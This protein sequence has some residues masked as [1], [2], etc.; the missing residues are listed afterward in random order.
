GEEMARFQF[1]EETARRIFT[2]HGYEELRTPVFEPTDL[3]VRGIGE[4]TD[5]VSKEMYTFKDRSERSLTLR[6][7]GT[8]G[9]VRAT[10][11]HGL[12]R[13]SSEMKV[14]YMGPMFRYERPQKGRQR[15]FHQIGCEWFG[16][17]SPWADAE[18][19][20]MLTIYLEA[21][22]FSGV[23]TRVNSIGARGDREAINSALRS[24]LEAHRGD[25][26]EDCQRRTATHPM[27]ALDCK[28]PGC[29]PTLDAAPPIVDLLSEASQTLF[30]EVC[31]HLETLGIEFEIAPRLVRGFDY[32]THT[33]F[34]TVL[35]GLGAQDAVLGGGR[36]DNL[37]EDLG[38]TSTPALGA[39]LGVE[40]LSLALQSLE[41]GPD[42]RSRV[43][44]AICLLDEAGLEVAARLAATCRAEGLRVRFDYQRR[45]P[46]AAL[47]DAN[48]VNAHFAALLGASEIEAQHVQLKDLESGNQGPVSFADLP[49]RLQTHTADSPQ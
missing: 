31:E 33:V 34:E 49:G 28:N 10:L 29:Q 46:K 17:A 40:R 6:P 16:N 23:R 9:V 35:P 14:F 42:L 41:A 38:G 21:C 7:E 2:I 18:T 22:G 24:H 26:C 37:F 12:L 20:A 5:I 43:D 19:I 45:S 32:Y 4:V 30:R 47:R 25:L 27:R 44:V 15:Q 48:R 3:F 1:L 13:Q 8:A 36:Y 39:S 11:E